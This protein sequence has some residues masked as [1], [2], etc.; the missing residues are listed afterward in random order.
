MNSGILTYEKDTKTDLKPQTDASID[1]FFA[2]QAMC[3]C[4]CV[5]ICVEEAHTCTGALRQKDG[6]GHSLW[7]NLTVSH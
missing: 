6:H 1:V 3:F 4:K 2:L 7:F 5:L